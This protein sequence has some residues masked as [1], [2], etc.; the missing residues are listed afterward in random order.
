[1]YSG[2]N[3]ELF[4]SRNYWH[5]GL[6]RSH[7]Y[8]KIKS[9]KHSSS[10]GRDPAEDIFRLSPTADRDVTLEIR[11][12]SESKKNV[13]SLDDF[14]GWL[15]ITFDIRGLSHPS[16][17]LEAEAGDLILDPKFHGR[18]YLNGMRLPCLGSEL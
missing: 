17:I 8:C 1:M 16:D 6:L 18:V 2:L 14:H 15:A 5:F 13:L 4:A 9:S 11:V 10:D 3:V 7:F 12:P